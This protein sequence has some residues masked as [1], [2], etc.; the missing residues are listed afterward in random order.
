LTVDLTT[1][2]LM[3]AVAVV[4]VAWS[5]RR[6]S[7]WLAAVVDVLFFGVLVARVMLLTPGSLLFQLAFPVMGAYPERSMWILRTFLFG[8]QL[9]DVVGL[10]SH[11]LAFAGIIAVLSCACDIFAVA[12]TRLMVRRLISAESTLRTSCCCCRPRWW[13]QCVSC[14]PPAVGFS[15]R[16]EQPFTSFGLRILTL[17]NLYSAVVP[18]VFFLMAAFVLLHNIIWS[19]G[20]QRPLYALR[21]F[22]A[23]TKHRKL[24]AVAGIALIAL[25]FPQFANGCASG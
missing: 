25:A 13:P 5:A 12:A 4:A 9:S 20:I 22:E 23:I 21:R 24:I 3:T 15:L 7:I 14:C 8:W 6:D 19:V 2:W 1:D 16:V 17:A 18:F 10:S 11:G